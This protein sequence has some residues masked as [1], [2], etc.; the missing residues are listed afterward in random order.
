MIQA[1]WRSNTEIRITRHPALRQQKKKQQNPEK[2]NRKRNSG[3]VLECDLEDEIAAKRTH[4]G[5]T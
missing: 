3:A 5:S 2:L 1:A 4:G